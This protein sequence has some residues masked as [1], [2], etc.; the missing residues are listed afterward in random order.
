VR[1]SVLAAVLLVLAAPAAGADDL[2][3]GDLS[4]RLDRAREMRLRD[5]AAYARALAGLDEREDLPFLAALV[6]REPHRAFRLLAVDAASRADA[7]E[8][9]GLFLEG[10]RGTGAAIRRVRAAGAVGI[11]GEPEHVEPL[12][13][14]VRAAPELVAVAAADAVARLGRRKDAEAVLDAALDAANDHPA[15]HAALAG[16][17]LLG[18][19]RKAVSLLRRS[20]G[21]G[22]KEAAD[23]MARRMERAGEG[24]RDGKGSPALLRRA[25]PRARDEIRV[26]ALNPEMDRWVRAGIRWLGDESPADAWLLRLTFDRI[27]APGP[28]VETAADHGRRRLVLSAEDAALRPPRLGLLLHRQAVLALRRLVGEPHEGHRGHGAAIRDG[29]ELA[30]RARS[31]R[32]PR[33]TREEH[34]AGELRLRPWDR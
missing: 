21:E 27:S 31:A 34:L 23:G 26:S 19:R 28:G 11:L 7:E 33:P 2:R 14:L 1:R 29:Y 8:A 6:P 22:R 25:L 4:A 15:L 24:R 32:D 30:V 13:E 9:A 10:A 16:A 5:P 20:A 3:E 18:S 17:D 12:L